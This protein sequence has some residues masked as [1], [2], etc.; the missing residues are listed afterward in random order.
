LQRIIHQPV[1][2]GR[3]DPAR[4]DGPDLPDQVSLGIGALDHLAEF[5]PE[6]VIV[7]LV[8]HV[9]TPAVGALLDPM[10]G[11]AQQ[12]FTR[13][14]V[15]HVE[16]RQRPETPPGRVVLGLPLA[17]RVEGKTAEVIPALV[18]RALIV[19]EQIAEGKETAS[20][21]VED[22]IQD[23][24]NSAGMRLSQQITEVVKRSEAVVDLQIVRR[25]IAVVAPRRED[26][27]EVDRRDPEVIQ[28]IQLLADS[29]QIPTLKPGE[30]GRGPPWLDIRGIVRWIAVGKAIR[31]DLIENRVLDP[32]RGWH[33][34]GV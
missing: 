7:D 10:P 29:P 2:R 16:L 12:E 26:R 19:V 24:P 23:D 21:V 31:K 6:I 33:G 4:I 20:G 15:G 32:G 30:S 17:E 11:D 3:A 5:G 13:G 14:P 18:A 1:E 27:I 9:E 8:R 22:P 25:V 34:A 28:V